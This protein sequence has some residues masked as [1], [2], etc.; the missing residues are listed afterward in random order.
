MERLGEILRRW[1]A[2]TPEAA[3]ATALFQG[4]QDIVGPELAAHTRPIEVE[5]GKLIVAVDHPG[6]IQLLRTEERAILKRL[7]RSHGPLSIERVVTVLNNRI[8]SEE[9]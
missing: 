5:Q 9:R 4:W 7:D 3:G 1:L 6:W 2:E 8:D